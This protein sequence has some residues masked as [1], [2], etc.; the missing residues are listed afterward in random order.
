MDLEN[1]ILYWSDWLENESKLIGRVNYKCPSKDKSI[2]YAYIGVRRS[3]K[4]SLACLHGQQMSK[5]L[6]YINFEDPYFFVN[7]SVSELEQIPGL[8]EKLYKKKL[9]L[10]ILDEIQ[11]IQGWEKWVRKITDTAKYQVI[12]TGSSAELLSSELASSLTGRNIVTRV[13][14]LSF[15][16]YLLF[17][18]TKQKKDY[19]KDFEK[20]IQIGSFPKLVLEK[21]SGKRAVLLREYFNNIL[22]KDIV[23]RFDIRNIVSF[24]T[25]MQYLLTN[26]SS[27]HS[28]NSI[29]KAFGIEVETA[30]DYADYANQA[31]LFFFLK[32]YDRN[33]KV[34]A[35][36][37]QKVYTIDTGLRQAN[38]FYH[39][40]DIGKLVENLCCIELLR[41][42]HNL[43]YHQGDYEVDF[44]IENLGRITGAINVCY[45]DLNQTSTYER[46]VE[47]MLEALRSYGLDQGTIVTKSL[48]LQEQIDSRQ[49]N[50]VPCWKWHLGLS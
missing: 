41:R 34:Q 26:I 10:L 20:Y 21:D 18:R 27:K 25:V 23:T 46:E 48:D 14:P 2:V 36:N 33:L 43:F 13:W 4:T 45:D 17:S 22:Y 42:G 28:F 37:P 29:K 9:E 30:Q 47:G 3:G 35:R 1:V 15:E 11:Y 31:F 8:Y 7:N 49:I 12:I 6:C 40:L 16:E 24:K 5:N 32:K 19:G 39:S 50:F 44:L 38:A